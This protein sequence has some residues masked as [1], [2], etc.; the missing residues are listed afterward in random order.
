MTTAGQVA[1][2]LRKLADALD[3]EPDT[4]IFRPEVDFSCKYKSSVGPG[5]AKT[6][7]IALA[8]LLPHPLTKG[9]QSYDYDAIEL[10][11]RSDAIIV[12]ASIER[13]KVCRLI[14]R[15]RAAVY[16]CEPL[17]SQEEE[18]SLA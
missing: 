18:A 12:A 16:D 4:E 1:V 6:V 9:V 7:F 15:E 5:V 8:R 17:L 11:Y 3:R 10:R 2:E 14:E 13:N